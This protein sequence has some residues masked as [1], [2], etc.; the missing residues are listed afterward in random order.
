MTMV[1][2]HLLFGA[3]VFLEQEIPG[4]RYFAADSLTGAIEPNYRHIDVDQDGR[5]DL[6]FP[7]RVLFQ[8]DGLYPS[9]SSAELPG[10]VAGTLC[11][12][13]AHTLYLRFPGG[14]QQL[15]WD[16]ETW[17]VA[18]EQEIEWPD[19]PRVTAEDGESPTESAVNFAR[20]LLDVDGDDIPEIVVYARDG[21]HLY[22][23]SGNTYRPDAV[24]DLYPQVAATA[25]ASGRVWPPEQR[26][27]AAPG[28]RLDLTAVWRNSRL[29]MVSRQELRTGFVQYRSRSYE[30]P[31]D[32]GEAIVENREYP[33]MHSSMRPIYLNAD[34]TL[35]F[36]GG[37][38][39]STTAS[40]FSEPLYD[41]F[42]STNEGDVV[43]RFRT[44]TFSPRNNF[45]DIDGDGDIDIV[46]HETGIT[47]GGVR[48]TLNRY[49]FQRGVR[50]SVSFFVQTESGE[51]V[52]APNLAV[53][54]MIQLEKAP[55][56]EGSMFRRYRTGDLI[57]VTGDFNGD[58]LKDI[59]VQESFESLAIYMSRGYRF[60]KHPIY[61]LSVRKNERF[62]VT[63]VD[64]NGMSDVVLIQPG[65]DRTGDRSRVYFA[66][67]TGS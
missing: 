41:T 19:L 40:A 63:D 43:H 14:L 60:S 38:A 21:V 32:G 30:L 12:T 26:R 37:A 24:I 29:T 33:L 3:T 56:R 1:L 18:A 35:D 22:R 28:Q 52:N 16:E 9:G 8:R 4:V 6:L 57:D 53:D 64:G 15:V 50:H 51:F 45:V 65:T 62:Y 44:K 2:L 5:T 34:S 66:R 49:F 58:G 27:L 36:A 25:A 67:Q 55:Y 20:F 59:V 17:V 61:Y 54:L 47:A 48:E 46:T 31:A 7:D 11:D 23:K 10:F 13:D 42:V 39:V